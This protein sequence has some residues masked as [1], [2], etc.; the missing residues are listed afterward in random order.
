MEVHNTL[1][2]GLLEVV[3]KDALEYEFNKQGILFQRERQFPVKYKDTLL[4]H[5]FYADFV[6]QDKIILE[7]KCVSKIIDEHI[8]QTLNYLGISKCKLGIIINFGEESL[9]HK[10]L[11][12]N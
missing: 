12:L 1:G 4:P 8:K 5:C 10:R 2:V 3:Y 6:V 7:I 11:V 9:K